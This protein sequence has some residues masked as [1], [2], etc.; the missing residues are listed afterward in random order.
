MNIKE[1][2]YQFLK[3]FEKYTGTDM[4]YLAK[5]GG[6]FIF[7]KS[8][9]LLMSLL[10]MTAF[11]R[12]SSKEVFGTYQY[13]LSITSILGIFSLPGIDTALVSAISRGYEGTFLLS[14]KNKFKWSLIGGVICLSISGWYFLQHSVLLGI[15]FLISGLFFPFFSTF[16]LFYAY[17][18]GKKRFD[19]L[20]IYLILLTIF[21]DLSL[22]LVIF[23]NKGLIFI[24]LAY[25]AVRTFLEFIFFKLTMNKI[26]NQDEE[27]ETISFGKHLTIIRSAEFFGS[28]IDK[29]IIWQILG[30]VPLAIYSFAILLIGK[31]L[32]FIPILPLALPK[33]SQKK[34]KELKKDI[35]KKFLKL[36]LFSIALTIFCI[37]FAP[38]FYRIFFAAYQDSIP[39][40]QVLALNLIFIPFSLL[41]TSLIAEKKKSELY[42]TQFAIPFLKTILFLILAP[43]WGIWGIIFGFLISQTL[44][45][46]LV[47]YFFNKL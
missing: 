1:K 19:V 16:D 47:F 44:S 13:I 20:N 40:F 6:W 2:I 46:G 41:I 5:G 38:L 37:L 12:W 30:P 17:W 4:I 3:W 42:I 33:I 15:S 26:S 8:I 28:Q 21:S 25:F 9:V 24:V 43:L 11:A 23:L 27:K 31:I 35:L 29:V 32:D 22:I 39:Y 36:F 10:T 34:I 7:G 14:A 18:N 45:N